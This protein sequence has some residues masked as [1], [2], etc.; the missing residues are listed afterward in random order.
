MEI[1]CISNGHGEDIVAARICIELE[2]LGVSAMALPLVGNGHA[3]QPQIPIVT[4]AMGGAIQKM[5]SGG[6]VRMDNKQLRRDLQNGLAQLTWKQLQVVWQWSR[7]RSGDR[8]LILAVG[9]IV[10]LLF[11]WL[12]T[13]WWGC[14]YVFVATA[15]SEYYWRD[16]QGK[17]PGLKPPFG[18]SFFY[19]WERWLMGSRHCR[20]NFVR[21]T[22]TEKW[23][24]QKYRL[25]ALYLGNPM[26]DG[27][28]PKGLDFGLRED[29][30]AIAILPGS[31][32]PEAYE[33][34]STLMVAAEITA[35]VMPHRA[36]FLA[37]ITSSLEL[38]K[39][40]EIAIQR[41]WQRIDELN[42]RFSQA[43]L[44][45]VQG[46]FGDCIHRAHLGLAMAGTATEQMVGLGKP[47]ITFVGRGPQFTAKFAREQV[48]LLGS[49]VICLEKPNQIEVVL[50]KILNDPDYFQEVH[51][52]AIERMGKAGASAR[53]AKYLAEQV[54][55]QS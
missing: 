51:D 34:W 16:R 19:P 9:D 47:V 3:Y 44:R 36:T 4:E 53:I 28:E 40:I 30:W 37:A 52:N 46:G 50:Q 41:G 10:P 31:R 27:L 22:L 1:L 35:K 8:R 6:F 42:Y 49:S 23:L 24:N 32:A 54:L 18:G 14:D 7:R 5:P 33:N 21:D 20:A 29:D 2:K 17:L 15:K 43:R 12:P 13:W 26:M 48:R 55:S 39:F 11:A 25:P 38:D 45:L